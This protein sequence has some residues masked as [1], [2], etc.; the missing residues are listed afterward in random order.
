MHEELWGKL[1]GFDCEELARRA[2]CESLREPA[3]CILKL[4][5]TDYVINLANRKIFVRDDEK[6]NVGYLEQLCLLAYL[7]GAKESAP[8]G[9]LVKALSLPGGAFFFRGPHELPTAKLANAFGDNPELLK[10]AGVSLG[11]RVCDHGDA[12]VELFVLPR[13]AM[14]FVVWAGDDEF[15]ARSSILF[16]KNAAEQLPLDALWCASKVAAN[17]LIKTG[18]KS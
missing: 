11:G 18:Q 1:D 8:A 6:A 4:A 15:E 5:N 16:D 17:V 10:K 13:V 3:R 12:A 14:V 9:K 2:G 7:I